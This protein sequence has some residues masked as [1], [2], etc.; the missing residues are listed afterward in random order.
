MSEIAAY[1]PLLS[2]VIVLESPFDE[3]CKEDGSVLV[4]SVG[5]DVS[6]GELLFRRSSIEGTAPVEIMLQGNHDLFLKQFQNL[7]LNWITIKSDSSINST[8][9]LLPIRD[10]SANHGLGQAA[11]ADEIQTQYVLLQEPSHCIGLLLLLL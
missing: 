7:E 1:L 9:E 4:I 8:F 6:I 10:S 2:N 5:A 3:A 11:V